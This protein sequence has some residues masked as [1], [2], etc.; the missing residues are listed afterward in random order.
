MNEIVILDGAMG[1]MLQKTGLNLGELPEFLNLTNENLIRNIHRKYL[2]AGSNIIYAN[3]FGANRHKMS[4]EDVVK[5]V[6]KAVSLAKE[7]ATNYNAKVALDIG[8]IG[9]LLEPSGTLSFD[10]AYDMFKE[11]VVAG[12]EADLIIFETMTDLYEVKA[13]VL[14]AKEC[15]DLPVFVTMTFEENGRT[16]AGVGIE[17]MAIT[18]EGLCVDAIGINCSLGP[19]EIL[20]LI[21]ELSTHT[22]LPIIAKPNAGLPHPETGVY[23][24]SSEVFSDTMAEYVEYG[25]KYLGGCCGTTDEYI[26]KLSRKINGLNYKKQEYQPR[27]R[28]CSAT[29]VVNVDQVRV[30][31]ERIN[32]TGKKRFV[33]ALKEGDINYILKQANEQVEAGADI[34]D[35]NVG[36]PELNEAELMKKVVKEVQSI[37]NVPLQIDSSKYE[38]LEAGL[39]YY[40]GKPILNSVNGEIEVLERILP[41]A[42]KYGAL[43]VGLTIDEEGIPKT[44][45]KR[46]EIANKI[47]DYSKKYGIP[48]EDILIDCL[49]LTVSAQQDACVQTLDAMNEIKK[50]L[51]LNMVLGVSNIS[52]GIPNR[53]LINQTFL[54]MAM[55]AGLTL[56]IIN[57]NIKSLMDTVFAYN[58]L[59]EKDISAEKYIERF[60]NEEKVKM[61]TVGKDLT[62]QEAVFKGLSSEVVVIVKNLL[63]EHEPLHIIN[64]ML[65]PTLDIVGQ[66]FESGKI[67]LPQLIRSANSSCTAFEVIKSTLIQKNDEIVLKDKIILATVKGDI[68]DI[69]KNIVKVILENYGYQV[70]DLGKDVPSEKI[71]ETAISENVKLIGLSALMTTTVESMRQTILEIRNSGHKCKIMVGG[72]VLTPE[73]AQKIGADFYAKDAKRSADITKEVFHEYSGI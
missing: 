34:L 35:I 67:F 24:L 58:V 31:G 72:A 43:V 10:D 53:E 44:A 17:N 21:K 68:H 57:P 12:E 39:R 48:K 19:V 40:N 52:F 50:D 45:Q 46:V 56:P 49:A 66:D 69:G 54:T 51:G 16:F 11:I 13:G 22:S 29:K 14:A 7:E 38:A 32:P 20:P 23:S 36:V 64:H 62:L 73:Y 41:L 70:I 63:K 65:I 8:P 18:L 1:T 26:H 47:L 9:E 4:S 5:I 25:V 3:T 37:L 60:S 27:T 6:K 71:V 30:I 42:K 2:Q 33:L 59:S 55:R 28:T 61:V 15:S